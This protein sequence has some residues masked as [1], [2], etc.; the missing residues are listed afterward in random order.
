MDRWRNV[1]E[2]LYSFFVGILAILCVPSS[3]VGECGTFARDYFIMRF[4]RRDC[5]R[6]ILYL[7]HESTQNKYKVIKIMQGSWLF[8][9]LGW[10]YRR[11]GGTR[12]HVVAYLR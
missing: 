6:E 3:L 11:R 7:S 12:A 4:A 10:E 8:L 5:L 2:V 1:L 9:I